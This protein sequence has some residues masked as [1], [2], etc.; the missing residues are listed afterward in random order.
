MIIREVLSEEKNAYDRVVVHPLQTWAWG[1]ARLATGISVVRLGMF[2][3]EHNLA[4]GW[5]LTVHPIPKMGRVILYCPR[6]P[7]PDDLLTQAIDSEARKLG[8]VFVKLEPDA[9]VKRSNE[10]VNNKTNN[11]QSNI[12]IEQHNN[13]LTKLGY[14]KGR[15]LFTE[16]NFLIDLSLSE[17]ELMERLKSKTR[18]N[19]RLAQKKGVEVE[20]DNSDKA[21]ERYLELEA[22]TVGRQKFYAHD[23]EYHRRVWEK[24]RAG[25]IAHLLAAKYQG[26]ILAAWILF[27]W[28]GKLYYP[29]GASTRENK[30]VMAGNLM[31]WEAMKWGK[32]NGC[33]VFD[34][35][36]TAGLNPSPSDNWFGFHK[37]KEGYSPDVVQYI[38]AYDY[39]IDPVM[40]AV[41]MKL[42]VARRWLLGL[43]ANVLG[44]RF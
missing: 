2:D 23:A 11:Q 39:V 16:Y 18:Y 24:M 43:K 31:M 42:D 35:W 5:L 19:V 10:Q 22:E 33:K 26:K 12:S 6:G 4:K 34:L 27:K 20:E 21:F 3:D 13:Q 1:E 8:A 30:E 17:D 14:R 37:F 29:Y 9:W 32:M 44:S 40:Y 25:G 41:V 38:G 7:V 15:N 36:G 28:K